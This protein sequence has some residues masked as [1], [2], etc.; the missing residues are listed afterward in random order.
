MHPDHATIGRP[1]AAL[2]A[3]W[4][5]VAL[6]GGLLACALGAVVA[7]ALQTGAVATLGLGVWAA[8]TLLLLTYAD[9]AFRAYRW[10]HRPGEGV[11]VWRGVWWQSETWIPMARLQHLDV[12]RGPLERAL[13]LATLE[14][15]TAGFPAHKTR[16][17]GLEPQE[18]LRLRDGLLAELQAAPSRGQ[19][20]P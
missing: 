11:V 10:Q 1:S 8:V 6:L 4:R 3:K 5:V 19:A 7:G 12:Q 15:Y 9:A 17:R 13:G 14:L 18:A 16:L 2:L 20:G